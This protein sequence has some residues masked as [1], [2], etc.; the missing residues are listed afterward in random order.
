MPY[1]ESWVRP[2]I[3]PAISPPALPPQP[4]T[5]APT[6]VLI[7][8][9]GDGGMSLSLTYDT[10]QRVIIKPEN[11]FKESSRR[12]T[13]VHVENPDDPDQ[14]VDFCRADT[15][16]Y[17]PK[18]KGSSSPKQSTYNALGAEGTTA[19]EGQARD[20]TGAQ[21]IQGQTL[22]TFDYPTST[23]CKSPSEP[24]RGCGDE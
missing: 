5:V 7:S 10:S 9:G 14:F 11:N 4:L 24:P 13:N 12:S 2:F 20:A 3:G 23:T 15:I 21:G 8:L 19:A 22:Y 18:N 17:T 16:G 1:L 6:D